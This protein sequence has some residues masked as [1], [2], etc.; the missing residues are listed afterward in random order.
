LTKIKERTKTIVPHP[1]IQ[2]S[3]IPESL[4]RLT[5]IKKGKLKV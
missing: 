1:T 3:E 2:A 4:A 5:K